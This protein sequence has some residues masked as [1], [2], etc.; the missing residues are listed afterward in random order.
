VGA[1]AD[2]L[3]ETITLR[4]GDRLAGA[5]RSRTT[6]PADGPGADSEVCLFALLA[7]PPT[8]PFG[9][10]SDRG[11]RLLLGK[12]LAVQEQEEVR[13]G[14]VEADQVVAQ[15]ADSRVASDT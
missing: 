3:G 7:T 6:D 2:D 8:A 11:P 12:P 5:A 10:V 4:G 14:F 1:R 13:Q 9:H 15:H